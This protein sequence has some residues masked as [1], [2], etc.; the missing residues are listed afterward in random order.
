MAKYWWLPAAASVMIQTMASAASLKVDVNIMPRM[1]FTGDSQT[2]GRVGALD[3]PQMLSWELPVRIINTAVGGTNTNHLLRPHTGGTAEIK[4]GEKVVQGTKVSWHS[5]P[6]PGM[7]VRLGAEEYVID[8]IEVVN[9][10]TA[11]CNL[12]LTEPARADFSGTDYAIEPGWE[13]RVARPRPDIVCFMYSVND[14]GATSEAFKANLAEMLQRCREQGVAQV[15]LLS[16]FPYMDAASGGTHPGSNDKVA[17]RARDLAEFAAANN[18][19]YGDVFTALRLLDP[20]MTAVWVDTVHPTTEGS[21]AAIN[22][23]RDLSARLGLSD[24]PYYVRGYRARAV[25]LSAPGPASL[26]PLTTSQP[27]YTRDNKMDDNLFDIE[28]VRVRDE[29][30]LLATADGQSVTSDTPLVLKFG[31]GDKAKIESAVVEAIVTGAAELLWYD[32]GQQ[33]WQPLAQ[34]QGNLRGE[35]S[36]A[37][38]GRGWQDGALWVAVRGEGLALDYTAVTLNGSLTPWSYQP[39]ATA[40]TWPPEL[41]YDKT[42][43]NLL[44]NGNLVTGE[45]APAGWTATGSQARWLREGVV[46][47]GTGEFYT[48]KRLYYFRAPGQQFTATVRPLDLLVVPAGPSGAV[49]NYLVSRVVNDETLQV[50]RYPRAEAAGL[51]FEVRHTSGCPAVPGGCAVQVAGES[52][53]QTTTGELTAGN[54][55]LGVYARVYDPAAMNVTVL[56]GVAGEVTLTAAGGQVL[57]SWPLDLSFQWQREMFTCALPQAGAVTITVKALGARAVEYTG[58]TLEKLP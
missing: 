1:L 32:A 15:V 53:W 55:R 18:L 3:Y 4:A 25:T 23:V 6:Y 26:T 16:G 11:L 52:V 9:Y 35:L 31:V 40:P 34:G 39:P 33:V 43:G 38:V 28:A 56:P 12:W 48:E 13:V 14:A 46:A 8:R 29:Y 5:G 10:Q 58:L 19:P 54:Y 24:N 17:V 37:Q 2:C 47:Q 41:L 20:Q 36:A 21:R 44:S 50:R 27:D 22:A 7:K 49:G 57:A 51:T 30:G 45:T 42:T